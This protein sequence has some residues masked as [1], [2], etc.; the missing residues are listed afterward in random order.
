MRILICLALLFATLLFPFPGHPAGQFRFHLFSESHSV[1]PQSSAS[2][3]GNYVFHLLYRGLYRYHSQR[4]LQ[5]AGAERCRREDLTLTCRLR[6]D[7]RWSNGRAIRAQD[8]VRAFQRLLEP[9]AARPEAGLLMTLKNARA[10]YKGDLPLARLGVRAA[11]ARD[12]E[13]TFEREDPEFEYKLIHP[14]LSPLPPGGYPERSASP[15]MPT[16]G[17]YR[18]SAWTSGSH[19]R[20]APNVHF[21]SRAKR[22]AVEAWIVDEDS[23]A[24]RMY[25]SGKLE[26]LRRLTAT[27]IPRYQNSP[28]FHQIPQAR[29]D[30]VGF[31][32]DLREQPELRA[33]LAH[34][35]DF[36]SFL[37]LFFTR[38]PPGCPSLPAR[39]LDQPSCLEF[40]AEAPKLTPPK[41]PLEFQF[42]RMG[43]DDITRAAE[44]FQGQWRA[45]LNVTVEL[46]PQEQGLYLQTLRTKP[47]AIF[48]KG[49]SLDRPTC[50]A[51]LEIFT[52]GHP[53]NYIQYD[54]PEYDR[55]VAQAAVGPNFAPRPKACGE[56]VRH[57]LASHRLIPLGE[58]Y[59]TVLA[60]TAFRGW[61]LNELNQLD[62]SELEEV[63]PK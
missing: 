56:A 61:D 63:V 19:I 35:V 23:T 21:P 52:H 13:I 16:S 45:R 53:E 27:E 29:F 28:E 7:H 6:R 30:Y 10:V 41:R 31:G 55:L 33:A 9:G 50:M 17:P 2:A 3:N 39:Y 14:A 4:G 5:L 32:P 51:G 38:S 57:L 54:D 37:R 36:Q 58:M 25:E 44:W 1:D 12:L 26:F 43:G 47:P 8:Y 11:S 18:V 40:H 20:F 34:A 60:K 62:L 48:R 22:P 15:R 42:S 46:R 49:V 59:F 24:L